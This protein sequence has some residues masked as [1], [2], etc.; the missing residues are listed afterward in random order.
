MTKDEKKAIELLKNFRDTKLNKDF[1]KLETFSFWGIRNEKKYDNGL[2]Y[3]DGDSTKVAY[4]IYY[5][6]Y[7][8]KIGD[9]YSTPYYPCGKLFYNYRGDTICTFNTIFGKEKETR[10]K[11]FKILELSDNEKIQIEN[12]NGNC[13][14]NDFYHIYQRVGNFYLLPCKTIKINN[15]NCSINTYRGLFQN[16]YFDIFLSL[17]NDK[18]NDSI[19]NESNFKKLIDE[20]NYFFKGKKL[21]DFCELFYLPIDF[22]LSGKDLHYAHWILSESNKNSYRNFIFEYIEKSRKMIEKRSKII[23]NE[24]IEKYPELNN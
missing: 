7:K 23:V 19:E 5:L 2:K 11:V 9:S 17:L 12:S 10:E 8:N 15:K 4:A 14:E 20:N 24:L 13:Y 3:A 18:L 1:Q 21:K 22:T 16:D 6:L